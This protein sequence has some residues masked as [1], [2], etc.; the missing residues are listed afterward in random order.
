MFPRRRVVAEGQGGGVLRIS[1][2]VVREIY[3]FKQ[4][5]HYLLNKDRTR[6]QWVTWSRGSQMAPRCRSTRRVV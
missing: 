6:E 5:L 3:R 1:L 2:P 4:H